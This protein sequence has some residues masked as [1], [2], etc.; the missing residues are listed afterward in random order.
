MI[1]FHSDSEFFSYFSSSFQLKSSKILVDLVLQ[2][3]SKLNKFFPGLRQTGYFRLQFIFHS[4]LRQPVFLQ[5][6]RQDLRVVLIRLLHRVTDLL[7][8]VR[9]DHSQINFFLSVGIPDT[10][11]K[12]ITV[13]IHPDKSLLCRVVII[14]YAL[15]G[16]AFGSLVRLI[17][18]TGSLPS[19]DA[20]N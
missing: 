12:L 20:P 13:E 4:Y 11:H 18:F 17:S 3:S 14:Q 9:I 7:E 2:H 6:F 10:I 15:Y 16:G 8:L 1:N 19:L 5:K